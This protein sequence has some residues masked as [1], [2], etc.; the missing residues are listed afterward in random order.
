MDGDVVGRK[1]VEVAG[2]SDGKH[3]VTCE[4]LGYVVAKRAFSARGGQRHDFAIRLDTPA[5]LQARVEQR[6]RSHQIWGWVGVLSGAAFGGTAIWASADYALWSKKYDR[7]E[8]KLATS[9]GNE[10]VAI[11]AKME[12]LRDGIR[13]RS[14]LG[15]SFA[16]ASVAA[17]VFG[18]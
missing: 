5:L 17:L 14:I 16:G 10:S 13:L 4:S 11:A 8:K 18:I 2:V 6:R 12:D 1:K 9:W 7:K 3:E 15:Y